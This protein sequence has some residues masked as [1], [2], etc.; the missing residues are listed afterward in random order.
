MAR[1]KWH[2]APDVKDMKHLSFRE[3]LHAIEAVVAGQGMGIFSDALVAQ[4]L[5]AGTLVKTFD[6]S[7]PGYGFYV[8]RRR[9][10]PREK[11]IKAFCNW[12]QAIR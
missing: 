3:E 9:N 4:E 2:Q 12:V 5:T 1:R 7:L 11:A 8:V 6:L 10:H